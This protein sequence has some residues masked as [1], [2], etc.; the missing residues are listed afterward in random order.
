MNTFEIYQLRFL[1]IAKCI[2]LMHQ[3]NDELK[4]SVLSDLK[5]LS[6]HYHISLKKVAKIDNMKALIM[7]CE[8]EKGA[9]K[10]INQ[11]YSNFC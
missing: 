5:E 3:N 11:I 2:R 1:I 8:F 6:K 4:T 7:F 10:C 9:D